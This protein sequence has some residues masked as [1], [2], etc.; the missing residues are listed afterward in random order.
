MKKVI[1]VAGLGA[2]LLAGPLAVAS[3]V[4]AAPASADSGLTSTEKYLARSYSQFIC[5]QLKIIDQGTYGNNL[6]VEALTN[7]LSNE[8]WDENVPK[9]MAA[10]VSMYCPQYKGM[11][12]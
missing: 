3:L 8:L 2:A 7:A 5:L 6:T 10:S 11:L 4:L 12:S 9:I 1:A